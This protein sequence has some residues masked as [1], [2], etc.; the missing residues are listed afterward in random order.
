M[1]KKQR[2]RISKKRQKISHKLLILKEK[3]KSLGSNKPL[4]PF[5]REAEAPGTRQAQTDFLRAEI[6]KL[7]AEISLLAVGT[8]A[9]KRSGWARGVD[10]PEFQR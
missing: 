7:E 5:S 8:R 6:K 1:D 2:D 10:A 4:P 3:L 9:Q